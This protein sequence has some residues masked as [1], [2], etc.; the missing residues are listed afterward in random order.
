MLTA[1]PPKE[2][3]A[4]IAGAPGSPRVA[5]RVRERR[6]AG[7]K[8]TASF[9]RAA[10][11][12]PR[13]RPGRGGRCRRGALAAQAGEGRG[14]SASWARFPAPG[15]GGG[16]SS[17]R[18][19]CRPPRLSDSD[20][21]LVLVAV[22]ARLL[23]EARGAQPRAGPLRPRGAVRVAPPRRRPRAGE[24]GSPR[25]GGRRGHRAMTAARRNEWARAARAPGSGTRGGA[26]LRP[27]AAGA[28][29]WGPGA[30]RDARGGGRASA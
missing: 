20:H 3:F 30:W 9:S 1:G 11:R 21:G 23:L 26:G 17:H 10:H 6:L 13:H 15:P 24:P 18:W 7:C 16:P 12:S 25:R 4:L 29:A 14:R 2:R 19:S 8:V 27:A 28:L 22:A 5:G